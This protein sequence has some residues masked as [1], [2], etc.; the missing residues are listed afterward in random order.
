MRNPFRDLTGWMQVAA[1]SAT[2]LILSL[3][4]CGLNYAVFAVWHLPLERPTIPGH[5][6]SERIARQLILA[7]F[8]ESIGIVLGALGLMLSLLALS[9]KWLVGR[10]G[11]GR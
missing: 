5:E 4:L 7:A 6:G 2:V 3:G 9:V 1:I 8:V 10:Y 11:E